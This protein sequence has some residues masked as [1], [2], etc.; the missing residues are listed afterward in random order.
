MAQNAWKLIAERR[1]FADMPTVHQW[2]HP[3]LLM[4]W[5]ALRT[6]VQPVWLKESEESNGISSYD[7]IGSRSRPFRF[8]GLPLDQYESVRAADP[9]TDRRNLGRQPRMKPRSIHVTIGGG[10]PIR[11]SP[12]VN[13]IAGID[14]TLSLAVRATSNRDANKLRTTRFQPIP[15]P[16]CDIF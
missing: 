15:N 6:P 8:T 16:N 10:G 1:S 11:R 3:P 5:T 7:W 2:K 13:S 12:V 14:A 4:L 9:D